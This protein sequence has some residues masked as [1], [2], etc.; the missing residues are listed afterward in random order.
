VVKKFAKVLTP[1]VI[2]VTRSL[3][4]SSL[5]VVKIMTQSKRKPLEIERNIE[6]VEDHILYYIWFYYTERIEY[7]K[8]RNVYVNYHMYIQKEY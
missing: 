3:Q 8:E 1:S 2:G 4:K 7:K 5:H 6:V